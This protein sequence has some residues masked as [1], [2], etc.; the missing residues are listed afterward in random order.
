MTANAASYLATINQAL[1]KTDLAT[2][3]RAV[4][5][6]VNAY[7]T[8]QT[9][10]TMGNGASAALAS[11]MACDWGKGTAP[12]LGRGPDMPA[13]RRLRVLSL[14]DNP[15]LVTAYSND[16]DYADVFIEQLKNLLQPGD[17]V[18]GI[19]GSGGSENVLRAM[20][21]AQLSGATTIGLTGRMESAVKMR[22]LSDCCIQ[23]PLTMMEQIEDLHVIYHHVISLGL[24]ERMQVEADRLAQT[25]LQGTVL[26]QEPITPVAG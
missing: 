20:K 10:F 7:C 23:A 2:I 1:R 8:G 15:A 11:H 24:R 9:V 22:A 17:V 25:A 5:L 19:S 6:L 26:L 12:D 3:D 13:M 16:L 14:N 4:S 18:L 21:F